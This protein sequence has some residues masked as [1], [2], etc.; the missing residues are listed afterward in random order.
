[1]SIIAGICAFGVAL[2]PTDRGNTTIVGGAHY[3]FAG[4]LFA[5][6]AWFSLVQFTK[7]S[8]PKLSVNKRKRNGIYRICGWVIVGALCLILAGKATGLSVRWGNMDPVY[9]L[10]TSALVAFGVSWMI[11]GEVILKD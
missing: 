10:E 4:T 5:I 7:S 9:W 1:M 6:L 8:H 3:A 2:C 11:K